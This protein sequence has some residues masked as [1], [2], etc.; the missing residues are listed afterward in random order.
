MAKKVQI[1]GKARITKSGPL[2]FLSGIDKKGPGYIVKTKSGVIG[3]TY[4]S[5]APVNGKQVVH[6]TEGKILCDPETLSITGFI[7]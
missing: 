4:H 2:G 6:T 7:D 1:S 3:R 5:D